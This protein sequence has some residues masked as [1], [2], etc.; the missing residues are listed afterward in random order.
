[1]RI[2]DWSSDVCSSDLHKQGGSKGYF[3]IHRAAGKFIYRLSG[4]HA[5][6]LLTCL[7]SRLSF[8]DRLIHN[9]GIQPYPPCRIGH[10]NGQEILSLF[11]HFFVKRQ[12][13]EITGPA[14]MAVYFFSIQVSSEE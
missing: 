8:P 6:R 4:T 9:A 14:D 12:V 10:M 7:Q 2:S 1:M 5:H 3:Q 13:N 11:Q